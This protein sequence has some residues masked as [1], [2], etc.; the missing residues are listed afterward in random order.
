MFGQSRACGSA[1]SFNQARDIS[2]LGRTSTKVG[3]LPRDLDRVVVEQR[4]ALRSSSF[5]AVLEHFL[6]DASNA[7][8]LR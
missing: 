3:A 2:S 1:A 8:R 4:A 7:G 5:A 6:V